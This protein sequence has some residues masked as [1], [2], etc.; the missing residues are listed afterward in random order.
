MAVQQGASPDAAGKR[1]K[2]PPL[3]IHIGLH[4]TGTT[5][6]QREVF[7]KLQSVHFLHGPEVN[8][9]VRRLVSEEDSAYDPSAYED[10]F[11]PAVQ[12]HTQAWPERLGSSARQRSPPGMPA[13]GSKP[14]WN[15]S[16]A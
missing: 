11:Y 14:L 12:A 13:C 3:F 10:Y 2:E 7:P 1:Q 15:S 16:C 5:F 9:W 4:R 8:Y 6:L